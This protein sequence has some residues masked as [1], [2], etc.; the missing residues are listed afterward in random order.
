LQLATALS[1]YIIFL[2]TF[3]VFEFRDMHHKFPY[4]SNP[5]KLLQVVI[6]KFY[7]VSVSSS[8]VCPVVVVKEEEE[9]AEDVSEIGR[10]TDYGFDMDTTK[11][12]RR[13]RRGRRGRQDRRT[14]PK[15]TGGAGGAGGA[16]RTG[17]TGG[18]VGTG[19]V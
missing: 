12:H 9:F 2:L 4:I 15:P 6:L 5:Q 10:A 1:L 3:F 7:R 11:T 8:T 19:L 14:L 16:G 17:G 18:T 13:G